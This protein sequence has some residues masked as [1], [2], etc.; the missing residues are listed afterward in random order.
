MQNV[1]GNVEEVSTSDETIT[2]S[3]PCHLGP[4]SLQLVPLINY[5]EKN[6]L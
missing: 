6:L 1:N 4:Q 2:V 5:L 3:S